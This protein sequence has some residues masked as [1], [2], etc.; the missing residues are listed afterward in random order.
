MNERRLERGERG[1]WGLGR[2]DRRQGE[3]VVGQVDRRDDVRVRSFRLNK[4]SVSLSHVALELIVFR[5]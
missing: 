4:V 2:E 3:G 1:R 5:Y